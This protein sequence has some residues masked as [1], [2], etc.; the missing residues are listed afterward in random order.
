MRWEVW[1]EMRW[2]V[3]EEVEGIE[4]VMRLRRS[5]VEMGR[6]GGG[7]NDRGWRWRGAPRRG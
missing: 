4:C 3:W 1:E 6:V 5:W 2:G 7:R